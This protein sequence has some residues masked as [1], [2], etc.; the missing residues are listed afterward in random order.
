M[1]GAT[2]TTKIPEAAPD[3]IVIIMDASC[4]ELTVTG[5]PFRVTKLLP[6]APPNPE[7]STSIWLPTEPVVEDR[8]VI[9]GAGEA[10]ELTETL[11]KVPTYK[12]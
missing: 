5:V 11:S 3:G 8:P 10:A 1:L 2:E 6:C 7:P 9:T 4:Q 12:H